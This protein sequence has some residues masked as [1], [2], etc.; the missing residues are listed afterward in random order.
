MEERKLAQEERKKLHEASRSHGRAKGKRKPNKRKDQSS[1][2]GAGS[3]DAN[4]YDHYI[5]LLLLGDGGVGKTSLMLRYAEN[6]FSST[7]MS[8]MGVDFKVRFMDLNGE[9]IKRQIWDTAGQE[10]FHVITTSYY[11]GAQG[12]VLTYDVTD[13]DS[14]KH[15]N[16]WMDNIQK[17]AAD[18]VR[19][20]LV[21]NKI[22]MENREVSTEEG[23]RVA[24]E[25]DAAYY[26]TSAKDGT[27]VTDAFEDLAAAIAKDMNER[28]GDVRSGKGGGGIDVT[29]GG[30]KKGAYAQCVLL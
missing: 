20:I 12:I 14:F 2:A 16:Y 24:S 27:N 18:D 25:H 10:R 4:R 13:P 17:H 11:R 26:E 9:R 23:E 3:D 28:G 6:E 1:G 19:V 5:K 21:A 7:M 30:K 22:D 8:T 29:G 15:V